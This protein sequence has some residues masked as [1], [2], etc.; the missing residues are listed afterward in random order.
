M[1]SLG[2]YILIPPQQVTLQELVPAHQRASV[3]GFYY[4]GVFILG[5]LWSPYVIGAISDATNLK[6]AYWV[7]MGISA[8]AL[9]LYPLV[10]R[11]FNQDYNRAREQEVELAAP[12]AVQ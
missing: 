12:A 11:F 1:G 3:F 2:N 8:V 9:I 5:G 7:S 6:A 10:Y 4:A